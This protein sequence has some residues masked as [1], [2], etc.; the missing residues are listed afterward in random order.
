LVFVKQIQLLEVLRHGEITKYFPYAKSFP[1][2]LE[3]QALF[4]FL[5]I[6]LYTIYTPYCY[7]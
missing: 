7:V 2:K 1:I 3:L 4:T 5:F 6:G